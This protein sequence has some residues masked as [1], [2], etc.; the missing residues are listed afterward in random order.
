VIGVIPPPG[1]I[2]VVSLR[3]LYLPCQV[4]ELGHGI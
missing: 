1:T 3:L 4:P 2:M